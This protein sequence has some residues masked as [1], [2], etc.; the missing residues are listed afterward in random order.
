MITSLIGSTIMVNG[1]VLHAEDMIRGAKQ[2]ANAANV[3]QLATVL[4][5]Y[6][7]DHQSYPKAAN[8]QA[9]IDELYDM[10]YIRNKPLDPN[11]FRYTV[12][13]GGEDYTLT[14]QEN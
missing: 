9:M 8:G 4:E 1:T 10:E 12:K 6:Y 2:T 5:L 11:V 3:H 7:A 13:N 14:L